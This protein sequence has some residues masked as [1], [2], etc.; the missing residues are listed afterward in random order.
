MNWNNAKVQATALGGYLAT[1]NS[2]AEND[3]LTTRFRI[4]HG[5]LWFGA[6][7]IA[8]TNTWVWDNGTTDNDNGLTDNIC[9]SNGCPNSNATWANGS[10]RKWES[11]EPNYSVNHS[12]D[13]CGYIWQASGTWDDVACSVSKYA[14]IEFD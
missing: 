12:G 8:T 7:D 1:V 9:G 10:T 4:Q 6:N 2:K 14:I 11:G 13:S 3:W 5:T